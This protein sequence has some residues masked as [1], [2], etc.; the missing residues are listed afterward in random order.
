M[1]VGDLIP[2]RRNDSFLSYIALRAVMGLGM[3]TNIE[4]TRKMCL[5]IALCIDG[6][7]SSGQIQS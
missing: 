6:T 5:Q 3:S 2:E 7:W 1:L 4:C